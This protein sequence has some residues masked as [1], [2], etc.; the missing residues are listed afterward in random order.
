MPSQKTFYVGPLQ[1]QK[2]LFAARGPEP[3]AQ[4]TAI[5]SLLTNYVPR[6]TKQM[7]SLVRIMRVLCERQ[8]SSKFEL[9][10]EETGRFFTSHHL[11]QPLTITFLKASMLKNNMQRTQPFKEVSD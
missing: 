5:V 1:Q 8:V 2:A 4:L 9:V 7:V 11:L 3:R 6:S 10:T